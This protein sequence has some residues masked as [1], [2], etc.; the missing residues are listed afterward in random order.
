[1]GGLFFCEWFRGDWD[2]FRING[3]LFENSDLEFLAL[4]VLDEFD[5]SFEKSD[6][7]LIPLKRFEDV[8]IK[9]VCGILI[10]AFEG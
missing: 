7:L 4:L 10:I 1:M 9:F 8:L 3:D 6:A 5:L 2:V